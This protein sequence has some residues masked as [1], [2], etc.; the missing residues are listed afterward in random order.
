MKSAGSNRANCKI[1]TQSRSSNTTIVYNHAHLQVAGFDVEE[2]EEVGN[3]IASSGT[4]VDDDDAVRRRGSRAQVLNEHG[5]KFDFRKEE[6]ALPPMVGGAHVVR[7]IA[8]L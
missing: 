5:E 4:S 1:V 8:I 2:I 3:V 6:F 7:D